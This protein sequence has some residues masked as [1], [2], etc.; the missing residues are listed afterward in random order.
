MCVITHEGRDMGRYW[1]WCRDRG[2]VGWGGG[3]KRLV[4]NQKSVRGPS[5]DVQ[6]Q[7]TQRQKKH[8]TADSGLQTVHNIQQTTHKRHQN[9]RNREVGRKERGRAEA[10]T[11]HTLGSMTVV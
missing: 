3:A 7:A 5:P 6:S 10:C 1:Q 4:A 8:Q 2:G 11:Q 9:T